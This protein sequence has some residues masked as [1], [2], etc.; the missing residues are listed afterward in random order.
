MQKTSLSTILEALLDPRGENKTITKAL[1]GGTTPQNKENK[2]IPDQDAF[3]SSQNPP[4]AQSKSDDVQ[5]SPKWARL[6]KYPQQ[7]TTKIWFQLRRP[8][9]NKQP[10]QIG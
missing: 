9:S 10:I 7:Q 4:L 5:R 1:A 6:H 8:E 2:Q 3:K